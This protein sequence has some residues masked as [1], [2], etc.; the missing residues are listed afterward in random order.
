MKKNQLLFSLAVAGV[1]AFGCNSNSTQKEPES[2]SLT[3][4]VNAAD[5]SEI[6]EVSIEYSGNGKNFKSMAAYKAGSENS[7]VVLVVPEWWGVNDYT[8]SRVKQLAALGYVAMAVD[9]YG[10]GKTAETPDSAGAL[11][12]PFYKDVSM[13]QSHFEAALAKAKTFTQA[14]TTKIA[15][16]GYCF[17]GGM[18]LN[19]ARL[20]TNLKGVASFHGSLN[21]GL[22][23][24]PKGSVIPAILVLH[25]EADSMVP[26]EEVSN[27]KKEMD[28]AGADYTF[29]GYPDAKHAFSNPNA[30]AVGEKYKLDIA[31]NEAADKA[32]WEEL[33]TFLSTVFK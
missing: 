7:P 20:G 4:T 22:P 11:A 33:K 24:P 17:G 14:D 6:T 13:A 3:A 1:V 16:I 15:A 18:V 28:N 23:A 2:D 25:G 8:K 29:I 32:S 5:S 30:T 27:F 10:D 26:A 19:M 31:Y 21:S 12:T 9:M